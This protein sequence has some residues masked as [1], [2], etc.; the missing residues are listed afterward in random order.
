[1]SEQKFI[2]TDIQQALVQRTLPTTT[3]WNRL[4]GRPRTLNFDRALKAEVRDAL[5]LISR[6]WQMGEYQGDDA[7]SPVLSKIHMDTTMLQEYRPDSHDAEPFP[8]GMPLEVEVEKRPFSF[9]RTVAPKGEATDH[10]QPMSLDLRLLMGRHW[11]KLLSPGLGGF[12]QDFIDAYAIEAP[13]PTNKDDVLVAA[14][15]EAWSVFAAV[16]GRRMDGGKLYLYLKADAN[17]HAYDNVPTVTD[18][19]DQ[20]TIDGLAERFV[21]W[22]ERLYCLPAANEADAWIPNR[23]EYQFAVSAPDG[24]GEKV[25]TAEEYYNGRLDWYNFDIDP[26][27]D[28]LNAPLP[29]DTP[30]PQTSYTKSFIPTQITFDGMPHTRWWTFEDK[31]TNFGDINPDTTDLSKLLL[32]EFGLVYANDWFLLPFE[33]PVGSIA[34]IR[35]MTVTNVFN[36]RIWVEAAGKGQDDD[37]QRWS[38]FTLNSVGENEEGADNSLLL[39]PTVTNVLESKPV[40]QVAL[41]RDEMANM[42]WGIEKQVALSTGWSKAGAET[43]HE[44]YNFLADRLAEELAITPPPDPPDPK[45][46]IRYRVMNSV[47]GHWIPFVPVHI[48]NNNREVQLQRAAMPRILPGDQEKPEK[49]RPQTTLLR[50]GLEYSPLQPY[51]LYEEEVL[52]TG[53]QVQQ[54]FKRTRWHGGQVFTWL[55]VSKHT[56]REVNRSGL[57][58]DQIKDTSDKRNS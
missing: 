46:A 41:I 45:A 14:H 4:E 28:D 10:I 22:F 7:G 34:K 30:D 26:A 13:D 16:A 55:G 1:M 58:F 40:E 35:G 36:E 5:W 20:L 48:E 24:E 29:E 31:R 12:V 47:P 52:R 6:Q 17:N 39:L 27:A 9:S 57:A 38:M 54:N 33:L 11:L 32:I 15:P 25:L 53:V 21:A 3:V 44:H 56:G 43:A 18:A 42:V 19:N 50:H 8:K 2:I 37:W 51:F 23:L 49:I